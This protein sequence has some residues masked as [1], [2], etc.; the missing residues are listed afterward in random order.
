MTSI[1][2]INPNRVVPVQEDLTTPVSQLEIIRG[3]EKMHRVDKEFTD[4]FVAGEWAVLGD[5]DKLTRPGATPVKNTYMV[6][7]GNDRS[8]VAATGKVGII[9]ASKFIARTTL[10]VAGAGLHVG[11]ALNVKDPLSNGNASLGKAAGGEPV[12][13]YVTKVGSNFIEF[14]TV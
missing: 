9:M 7:L 1:N 13:A 6:N 12:L 5:N 11:D 4:T 10:F 2:F 3:W 8:D 14:E